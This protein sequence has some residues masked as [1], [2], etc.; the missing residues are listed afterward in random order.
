MSVTAAPDTFVL[1]PTATR[2][3][4]LGSYLG[5]HTFACPV[6]APKASSMAVDLRLRRIKVLPA[7]RTASEK[8]NALGRNIST[9]PH[10]G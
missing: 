1:A 9:G 7:R 6:A 10:G 2:F 5:G 4:Q 3:D 8:S